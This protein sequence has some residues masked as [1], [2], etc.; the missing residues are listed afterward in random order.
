ML[1]RSPGIDPGIRIGTII[2]LVWFLLAF[3]KEV[4]VNMG[5]HVIA[6]V[7]V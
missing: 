4:I 3:E 2:S 5:F 7:N 1:A 6:D